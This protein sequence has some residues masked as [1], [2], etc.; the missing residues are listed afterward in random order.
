MNPLFKAIYYMRVALLPAKRRRLKLDYSGQAAADRIAALLEREEAC[1]IG[2]WGGTE[3]A[4]VL[5]V[6][7]IAEGRAAWRKAWRVFTGEMRAVQRW[8]PRLRQQ[9]ADASG[10]FPL[11]DEALERFAERQVADVRLMDIWASWNAEEVRVKH[12]AP[13]AEVIGLR[14]LRP[15]V[16][17]MPWT[18][19]LKGKRVLVVHPFEKSIRSQYERRELLFGGREVL[20]EFKLLTVK[21]VQSMGG[22]AEGYG[23]WFEA[24]EAMCAEIDAQEYDV[25]LI[26]AGAYGL[27]LGAHVKRQ[28]KRAVHI[29]GALQLMFGIMGGCWEE[30]EVVQRYRNEYWVRPLPEEWPRKIAAIDGAAYW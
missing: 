25:A 14:D 21:A 10:F 13:E 17:E 4:G 6:W 28:G 18:R 24:L 5:S 26:G 12:L 29:G 20:P 3:L 22:S 30:D 16:H 27:P 8:N 23:S 15:E 2:R 19:V 11:T 1:L 7:D 9:M